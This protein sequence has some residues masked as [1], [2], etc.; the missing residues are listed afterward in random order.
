MSSPEQS[1]GSRHQQRCPRALA[2]HVPNQKPEDR[3]RSEVIDEVPTHLFRGLQ[4]DVDRQP[5]IPTTPRKVAGPAKVAACAPRRVLCFRSSS[6]RAGSRDS[7]SAPCAMI[8][9]ALAA[10][11]RRL[12]SASSLEATPSHRH[13]VACAGT[14]SRSA[15][16]S[17]RRTQVE[18]DRNKMK[19]AARPAPSST[20]GTKSSASVGE[21]S[22]PRKERL[23]DGRLAHAHG[24]KP[25]ISRSPPA[26]TSLSANRSEPGQPTFALHQVSQPLRHARRQGIHR[27]TSE[28][29]ARSVKASSTPSPVR[30]LLDRI[31][32]PSASE[33][34]D[35]GVADRPLAAKVVLV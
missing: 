5:A 11:S 26:P 35:V 17:S 28:T 23:F 27:S 8:S 29:K 25:M 32:Q 30:A 19:S 34:G 20:D 13:V 2:G 12:S 7:S 1:M 9:A 6:P 10:A 18:S 22:P 21:A 3:S 14:A 16:T 4:H 15:V 24:R 33:P 31:H